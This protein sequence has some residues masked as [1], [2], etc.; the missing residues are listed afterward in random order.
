M[1][2]SLPNE[3]ER[4]LNLTIAGGRTA[5]GVER[6]DLRNRDRTGWETSTGIKIRVRVHIRVRY[7]KDGMI[8]Q[9]EGL[10][11]KL[12]FQ[13]FRDRYHLLGRKVKAHELWPA[14]SAAPA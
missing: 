11:A 1:V 5:D 12:Q 4:K 3:F 8:Q 2:W 6:A 13:S 9:V 10:K 14:E 7:G